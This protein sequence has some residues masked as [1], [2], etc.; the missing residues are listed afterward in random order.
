M[1]Q[2]PDDLSVGPKR[3]DEFYQEVQKFR[4]DLNDGS[5]KVGHSEIRSKINS[6]YASARDIIIDDSAVHGLLAW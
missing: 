2:T 4:R 1:G 5:L 6:Q 3:N